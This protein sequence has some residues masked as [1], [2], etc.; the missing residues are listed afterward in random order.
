MT[1]KEELNLL[2]KA[3]LEHETLDKAEIEQAVKGNAI[4][5]D[6]TTLTPREVL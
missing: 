5:K 1:H 3:L 2:A 4:K 6:K